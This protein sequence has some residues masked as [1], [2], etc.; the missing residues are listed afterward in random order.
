MF[1]E[2]TTKSPEQTI[3]LGKKLAALLKG[4]DTVLLYGELGSGKTH[5]IKG[6]AEGLGIKMTVKSPTYAYVN[7][8]S[9]DN[10]QFPISNFQINPKS[11]IRNP[12]FFYHYD[13]YRLEEGGDLTSI[14]YDETLEDPKAINAVEWADRLGDKL[15]NHYIKVSLEG[16]GDERTIKIEFIS[17]TILAEDTIESYF[18]E[19][20]TPEHVIEHC[21]LVTEV[22]MKIA[23]AYMRKGEIIN[24][25]LLYTACM[26]HDVNRVCDFKEMD[27]DR[28]E[29][30]VTDEKWEKWQACRRQFKGMHHADITSDILKE[31]GF[32]DTAELVR[33]HKSIN[34][35]NEPDSYD[36]LEKQI[37]YYADK[38]VAHN[39][40]VDLGERFRDGLE[41]YGKF[42]TPKA[43]Q[44]SN[45][46]E[47]RTFKLEKQL[48][49]GLDISP[50]DI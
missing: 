21:H 43:R 24:T 29:E 27:R 46:V 40:I 18:D 23:Q 1:A 26:M 35:V 42:D 37:I 17:P 48:F 8:Y 22:A 30:D 6:I 33:L 12:K 2:Y 3:E 14:G 41:R 45:E 39:K 5:F 50:E 20:A 15:P 4:G 38:R 9:I 36:T 11:E 19:W 47:K 34:I 7:R 16:S 10:F 32:T 44:L 13:L 31:R 49:K 25:N 28:F